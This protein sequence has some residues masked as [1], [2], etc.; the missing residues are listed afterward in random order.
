M[1]F[2]GWCPQTE[3][4]GFSF[5]LC[6]TEIWIADIQSMN[7]MESG[8][9]KLSL[10]SQKRLAIEL[11][12]EDEVT[13][14]L[15]TEW[16]ILL[17]IRSCFWRA[18]WHFRLCTALWR[19]AG[20]SSKKAVPSSRFSL[21]CRL[22]CHLGT[23]VSGL[24]NYLWCWSD[25]HTWYTAAN[26]PFLDEKPVWLDEKPVWFT[27]VTLQLPELTPVA[28]VLQRAALQCQHWNI[29]GLHLA[30]RFLQERTVAACRTDL[31][32]RE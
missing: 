14:F 18:F 25:R 28:A 15:T 9:P 23:L 21:T 12:M 30:D 3:R 6:Q 22:R 16:W 29:L 2:V 1:A 20:P 26:P 8:G 10:T 24:R 19:K 17:K 4:E 11:V 31:S 5:L 13:F 32:E 27:L 7:F